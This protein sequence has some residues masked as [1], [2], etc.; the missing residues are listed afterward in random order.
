MFGDG[1]KSAGL[2]LAGWLASQW[3]NCA[4]SLGSAVIPAIRASTVTRNAGLKDW[5]TGVGVFIGMPINFPSRWRII[6]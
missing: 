1:Q 6:S 4:G 5:Q 3:R 2:W